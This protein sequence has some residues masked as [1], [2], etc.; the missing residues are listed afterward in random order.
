MDALFL[1]S[2]PIPLKAGLKLLGLGEE[3][4]RLPLS[5]AEPATRAR[6]AEGL[7]FAAEGAQP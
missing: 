3:H 6:I 2:N 7:R 4:L 5:A 1:E